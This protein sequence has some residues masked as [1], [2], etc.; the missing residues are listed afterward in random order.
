MMN[1]EFMKDFL[2]HKNQQFP[3]GSANIKKIFTL[4]VLLFRFIHASI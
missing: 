3:A 1:I 4:I 2:F